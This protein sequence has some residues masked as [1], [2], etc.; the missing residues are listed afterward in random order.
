MTSSLPQADL[1]LLVACLAGVVSIRLQ[2]LWSTDFPINDGALFLAFVEAIARVFPGIPQAV[3]YNGLS[4]PFAYPPLSFWLSAAAVRLGLDPLA[5]VH[6]LPI[7]M[8]IGYVLLFTLLLLRTGHS[9]LFAAIAVLVFGTSFLSYEWLVMGG[10]LSRGLGSVFLLLSLLVLMPRGLP[11][12]SSCSLPRLLVGGACVAGA[13]LSHLEWGML[14]A[15]SALVCLALAR[16]G[17][18]AYVRASLAVGL[19]AMLIV[20][21]WFWSVWQ[22]HG[23]EPFLAAAKTGSMSLDAIPA[24]AS[25]IVRTSNFL[26]PFVLLGVIT[27]LRTRDLF[28]V[29][30]LAAALLLTPRSGRTPMVLALGVLAASGVL[31]SFLLLKRWVGPG[32]RAVLAGM[33]LVVCTLAG[34]R[35]IDALRRDENFVVLP[36]ELREAMAWVQRTHPGGTFAVLK[37]SPWYYNAAA[38]WFPILARAVSTTT[39]QGREWLPDRDFAR[40]ESAV[41][42]FN[43]ATS[44]AS[45]MESLHGFASAEFVWAEG[46]DLEARAAVIAGHNRKTLLDRI[47]G[48]GRSLSGAPGIDRG[49]GAGALRGPGTLA[50]CFDAA[51]YQQVY[52]NSRVRIFRTPDELRH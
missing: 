52:S 48:I 51:G 17:W 38:E 3:E 24:G 33:V 36:A 13:V 37:E 44:C 31:T 6:R 19:T 29:I 28:W 49:A 14:A 32:R 9:R 4:I 43:A 35:T 42:E 21:P 11:S 10:G 5:I 34:M 47:K 12:T 46:V 15:F 25:R 50:G 23:L 16:P 18:P 1:A 2:L 45:V 40:A 26:L 39:V 20:A 22:V 27:A 41:D 30:F 7:L 8:N